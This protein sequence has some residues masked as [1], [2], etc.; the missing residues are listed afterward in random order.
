[1]AGGR[2][3]AHR[4]RHALGSPAERWTV[5]EAAEHFGISEQMVN[6]RLNMT[7]AR[8]RVARTRRLRV[9]R[10]PLIHPARSE[11]PAARLRQAP[12]TVSAG[13]GIASGSSATA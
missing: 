13:G 7:G 6:Y 12:A 8:T 2:A 9:V 5:E 4:G 11:S 10:G 1:M 3:P